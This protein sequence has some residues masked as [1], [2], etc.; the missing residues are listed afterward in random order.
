MSNQ[1]SPQRLVS[2]SSRSFHIKLCAMT[3][4][5]AGAWFFT[6][7]PL[8]T[9]VAEQRSAIASMSELLENDAAADVTEA[10]IDSTLTGLRSRVGRI[11]AWTLRPGES[12]K[13]YDNLR[14]LAKRLDVRIERIEPKGESTLGGTSKAKADVKPAVTGETIG[15]ALDVT[16]RFEAV[17]RFIAACETELGSSRVVSF[18]ITPSIRPST[19]GEPT[20]VASIDTQHVCLSFSKPDKVAQS[21]SAEDKQ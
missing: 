7:R 21:A 8:V 5:A 11:E 17:A 16:G 20:V 4:L 9:K 3:L 15:Y 18:R 12:G 10:Q 14:G 13:L 19:G 1:R 6:V 2:E